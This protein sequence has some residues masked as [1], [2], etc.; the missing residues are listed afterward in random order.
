MSTKL[1]IAEE[2]EVA[3]LGLRAFL[4][5]SEFE[6][7]AEA[8][9]DTEAIQLASS[10]GLDLVLMSVRLPSQGGFAAFERI[11]EQSPKL[12]VVLV[13]EQDDSSHLARA[14]RRRAAAL[15]PKGVDREALL[16]ALRTVADGEQFWTRAHLRRITGVSTASSPNADFEAALTPREG[17]VLRG[18]TQGLTNRE[19][20]DQL[21][22]SYETV[23][24]HVQHTL[25]KIGVSDRTQAAVWAVRNALAGL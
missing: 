10:A 21:G 20:G 25:R 16:A 5:H 4:A 13:A 15:L 24:E 11:A 22:I 7:I 9:T 1:L 18:V 14:Y 2:Q 19:I 3:R 6:V 17:E 23:K 12:P 8:V